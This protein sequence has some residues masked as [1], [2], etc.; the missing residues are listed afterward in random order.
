[1]MLISFTIALLAAKDGLCANIPLRRRQMP[2]QFSPDPASGLDDPTVQIADASFGTAIAAGYQGPSASS[3]NPALVGPVDLL[4]SGRVNHGLKPN[5]TMPLYYG[6]SASNAS[7]WWIATDTSDKGNAKQLG[8]NYAPKLR[9]AAQSMD[10]QGMKAA[11]QLELV[12]NNIYGRRGMVD[13]SPVR[14]TVAGN[15]TPFPPA[16]AEPGSRGDAEYTPLVQLTNAGN[17]VWNAPIIAGDLTEEYLNQFCD[18]VP[19]DRAE[20]FY[21]K[22]HDQVLAICPRDQV[23][24]FATVRGF[25][26]GKSLLYIVPDSSDV[27]PAAIDGGTYAPRLGAVRTGQ[28]DALFS[29]VERI[30]VSTNGYTNRDLPSGAPNNEIHHPWRQGLDSAVL[31]EGNPLNVFGAIPTVAFDY[32]PLGISS[33]GLGRSIQSEMASGNV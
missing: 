6:M 27:L 31:G 5:Y 16:I 25:S 30:F 33:F 7:Y 29:A 2:Y 18:G 26:F 21:S 10:A 8:L 22:V 20:D 13:F 1:M 3:Q 23:V 32:S 15:S 12:N 24:T 9:F 11:E 17:E 4:R 14:N 28:D 19:T